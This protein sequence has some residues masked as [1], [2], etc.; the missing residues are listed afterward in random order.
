MLE[1][2][3]HAHVAG[4]RVDRAE[5]GDDEQRP[6]RRDA[7]EADPGCGHQQRRA[8]QQD[9]GRPAV[10]DG[11]HGQ[12]RHGRTGERGRAEEADVELAEA[13]RKQVGGQ[14]HGDVAV[15]KG[16]QA[17]SDEERQNGGVDAGRKQKPRKG[18]HDARSRQARRST[19]GYAPAAMA[20]SAS[21][22][23]SMSSGVPKLFM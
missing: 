2:E 19:A 21:R 13:E 17:A 3:E 11:T 15:G 18:T 16:A 6:E 10:T 5:E 14:Q 22:P 7:G 8:E 9:A 20:A 1:R 12:C 4:A 23:A